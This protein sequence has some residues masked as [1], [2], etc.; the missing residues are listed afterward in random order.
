MLNGWSAKAD[1]PTLKQ[2]PIEADVPECIALLRHIPMATILDQA[3]G[4]LV[5][6]AFYYLFQIGKYMH[7]QTRNETKQTIQFKFEDISFFK[8]SKPVTFNASQTILHPHS[9]PQPMVQCS[10][11]TIRKMDGKASMSS[12]RPTETHIIA[13]C[14]RSDNDGHTS[15]NIMGQGQRPFSILLDKQHPV[16]WP[17]CCNIPPKWDSNTMS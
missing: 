3:I 6:I 5:L 17:Q 7:K 11:W 9:S 1:P 16:W 13:L 10:N 8:R 2:L 14:E 12:L 4:G 15:T